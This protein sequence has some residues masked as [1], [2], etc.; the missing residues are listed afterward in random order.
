MVPET[1]APGADT[2]PSAIVRVEEVDGSQLPVLVTT[3][4][5]HWPSYGCPARA[6]AAA[7]TVKKVA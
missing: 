3:V 1:A 2:R 4:T 5:F 6:G 7:A